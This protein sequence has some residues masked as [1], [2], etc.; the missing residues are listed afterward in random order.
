MHALHWCLEQEVINHHE[1]F[2]V[3][4]HDNWCRSPQLLQLHEV[5]SRARTWAPACSSAAVTRG[6][7]LYA[8]Q[9]RGV[10]PSKSLAD[11]DAPCC[12]STS[13]MWRCPSAHATCSAVRSSS[14]RGN[15]TCIRVH[16]ACSICLNTDN[17]YIM[18][19]AGTSQPLAKP[20]HAHK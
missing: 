20:L 5:T 10:H 4:A 3:S 7:P 9:C 6:S 11:S 2:I 15:A 18:A 19:H 8:A 1:N 12:S 16:A 14:S 13:T 17:G